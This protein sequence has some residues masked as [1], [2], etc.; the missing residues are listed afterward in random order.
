MAGFA[1]PDDGLHHLNEF[2]VGLGLL[3][4]HGGAEAVGADACP[5]RERRAGSCRRARS[6][7]ALDFLRGH[8]RR[9]GGRRGSDVSLYV[10]RYGRRDVA[11]VAGIF[12]LNLL[13]AFFTINWLLIGGAEANPLMDSLLRV[14]W[15]AFVY[16]KIL[17]VGFSLVILI[18]HKNFR[19]AQIGLWLL[20]IVYGALL[21][22]HVLLQ[23]AVLLAG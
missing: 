7:G 13:D 17:V 19:L 22:Y 9:S 16:E 8:R 6:T 23:G 5:E 21:L 10:D 14:S 2:V 20:G 1:L 3:E 15:T 4:E 12:V 11:V 18:V